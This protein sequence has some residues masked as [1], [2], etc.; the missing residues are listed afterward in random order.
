MVK[1]NDAET[2][3]PVPVSVAVTIIVNWPVADG[4]P[5]SD[6]ATM[7][8]LMPG[9]CAPDWKLQWIVPGQP[10]QFAVKGVPAGWRTPNVAA[11][12]LPPPVRW[13]LNETSETEAELVAE[14]PEPLVTVSVSPTEPEAPAVYVT[15]CEVWPPVIVPLVI[16]QEYVVAPAGPLAVLPVELGHADGEEGV[17]VGD[18]GLAFT[19]T[20]CEFVAAQPFAFVTVSVSVVVPATPAV[21]VMV[22]MFVAEVMV[23]LVMAHEYVV[24]PAGPAAVLPVELAQTPLADGVIVGAEGAWTMV[25]LVPF[26][27]EQ[28]LPSV[29]V[30]VRPTVP[31]EPAGE[32]AVCEGCA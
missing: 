8:R 7:V 11:G 25:T 20:S 12:K 28:P 9:G 24:A 21:Q 1:G 14:Q 29:T 18:D 23:P 6:P 13:M 19:V 10:V 16:D 5:L 17:I 26:E 30:R 15:V 32:V 2:E 3:Q 31:E 22:W 27:A 4:M